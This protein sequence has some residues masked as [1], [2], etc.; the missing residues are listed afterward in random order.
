MAVKHV[1]KNWRKSIKDAPDL[2]PQARRLFLTT[3]DVFQ[4]LF[5]IFHAIHRGLFYLNG[6]KYQL[7][8]RLFGINYVLVR[9]W[10][11]QNHSIT[12][13]KILGWITLLQA[14]I[15]LVSYLR[16]KSSTRTA[17]IAKLREVKSASSK[18]C[19]LCMDIRSNSTALPCGHIFCWA[20][21]L[22][23]L[24]QKGQCPICRDI[25]RPSQAV[26]L[27]NYQKMWFLDILLKIIQSYV[28]KEKRS[29]HSSVVSRLLAC[30]F[31]ICWYK[32]NFWSFWRFE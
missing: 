22:D 15:S 20:C 9:Y 28:Q 21:V 19:I 23:W 4:D 25:T 6:R 13:Y 24:A 7:S 18:I 2:T 29:L 5:P 14:L 8:K 31:S 32:L 17:S 1:L 30:N 16:R 3:I 27:I 11:K 10:L 12:G 26:F